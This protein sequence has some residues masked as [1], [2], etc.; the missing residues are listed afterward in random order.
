V[1]EAEARVGGVI[2]QRLGPL[3]EIVGDPIAVR[4]YPNDDASAKIFD[5]LF[6]KRTVWVP[7]IA[8]MFVDDD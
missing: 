7:V 1:I 8:L 4:V 2:G 3:E 5:S 6:I